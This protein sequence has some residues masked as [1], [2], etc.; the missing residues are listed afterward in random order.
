[1][2]KKSKKSGLTP[3]MRKQDDEA[4]GN[5]WVSNPKQ[6]AFV[7]NYMSPTS[8]TFGNAYQSAIKAKYS[9]TYARVIA[10]PSVANKWVKEYHDLVQLEPEHIVSLLQKEAT[11][12]FRNK[13]AERIAAL[14]LLA[15]MKGLLVEKSLVAHVNI[16]Q[17]LTDLK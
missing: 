10:N 9:E 7:V 13:G 5:Q 6:Q 17:A 2:N 11:D 1:M 15:Q 16:E 12:T 8:D 14:K 4:W 3:T